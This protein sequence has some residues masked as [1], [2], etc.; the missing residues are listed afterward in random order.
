MNSTSAAD[1]Q[2]AGCRPSAR[3]TAG[4]PR[5]G[6]RR[7]ARSR[8][9]MY[10]TILPIITSSG[11]RRRGEQVLHRAA[12]ALAR[13]RQRR[14]HHHRHRQDH[15]HQ[16]RHDVVA[17]Q[18]RG[19]SGAARAARTAASPG[20]SR[21]SGPCRS[22]A[23]RLA[24]DDCASAASALPVAAGSVASASSSSAGRSP[25]SRLAREI[26]RDHQHELHLAARQQAVGLGLARAAAATM[27]K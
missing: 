22:C 9:A 23:E 21:A 12:L 18:P 6:S 7:P 16:A 5:P 8:S 3:R 17:R 1:Q 13:H 11:A 4:A 26:G 10:G 14:H 27:R 15:A 24:R 2:R 20:C 19:C 25:R